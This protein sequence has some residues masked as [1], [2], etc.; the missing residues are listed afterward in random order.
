[1]GR[2]RIVATLGPATDRDDAVAEL[3]DA[4]V[5]VFRLELLARIAR[6]A[7]RADRTHPA[8]RP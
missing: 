6:R 7:R 4:G 1:M 2:T 5:D 8:S 3:I